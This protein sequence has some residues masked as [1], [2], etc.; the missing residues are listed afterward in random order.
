VKEQK[1]NLLFVLPI[2][3]LLAIAFWPDNSEPGLIMREAEVRPDAS[4]PEA[5]IAKRY[6]HVQLN[7][8]AI[9]AVREGGQVIELELFPGE[10]VRVRLQ[11]SEQTGMQ[12]T[13]VFGS[14]EGVPGSM[15]TLVTY[16]D[17][18]AG[19]VQYPDGRSFMV[20]YAGGAEHSIVEL[21][22]AAMHTP[23]ELQEHFAAQPPVH[24]PDGSVTMAPQLQ[25][26]VT[27]RVPGFPGFTH[28][29]S[30]TNPWPTQVLI[31]PINYG[32]PIVGIMVLYTPTAKRQCAG[33]L[34][35]ESRIRLSVAQVN[36]AFRR[37]LITA[38]L[39][40]LN[41]E[42]V[43]YTTSGNLYK[44]LLNLTFGRTPQLLEVHKLR[45]EH[46]ADL[47]SLFVGGSPQ[48]FHGISW[49]LNGMRP[50]PSYGFNVVEGIYAPTSVFAHEI[51]HNLGC[52]HATNDIGGYLHG[53]Y[54][55][56]HGWRFN[57]TTNGNTY[58]MRTIMAYGAGPRLGYYSTPR[59]SIWGSPAG[60]A[61]FAD[62][63]NTI[64]NTAPMVGSY[65]TEIIH[66]VKLGPNAP[67]KITLLPGTATRP[68]LRQARRTIRLN[69]YGD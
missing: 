62:N 65:M 54:T 39:V 53:A 16:E 45:Q 2:A 3:V 28:V 1:E 38:K 24:S 8:S 11:E 56:S 58:P 21:D 22:S 33:L 30:K 59:V 67:S 34:G 43:E 36:A 23:H 31:G 63:A 50:A 40:L 6:R 55:N 44:D 14:I 15:V 18:L 60:N 17:V 66:T 57:V 35:V 64:S 49:M 7:P 61:A 51:G 27:N 10:T 46:R 68:G 4:V 19:M 32:P 37:S 12:S 20:N 42:E 13:E 9:Q 26:G 29:L 69:F 25:F 48:I 5:P 47:V 41:T 52:S